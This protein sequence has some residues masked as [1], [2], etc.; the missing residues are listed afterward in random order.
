MKN[1]LWITETESVFRRFHTTPN[2]TTT[3]IRLLPYPTQCRRYCFSFAMSLIGPSCLATSC[4]GVKSP[5]T[6]YH[7]SEKEAKLHSLSNFLDVSAFRHSFAESKLSEN[8]TA[9]SMHASSLTVARCVLVIFYE[10]IFELDQIF[11]IHH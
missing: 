1:C 3:S 9:F 10:R 4:T 2:T 5:G 6:C 7:Q 8:F 11:I